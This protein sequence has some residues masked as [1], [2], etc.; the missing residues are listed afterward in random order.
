ML[1]R[2]LVLP[3]YD[4]NKINLSLPVNI[5]SCDYPWNGLLCYILKSNFR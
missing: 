3:W 4:S 1:P 2:P 5:F